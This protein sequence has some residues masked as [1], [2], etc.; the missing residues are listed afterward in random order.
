MK[1]TS[2]TETYKPIEA[3]AY[4]QKPKSSLFMLTNIENWAVAIGVFVID[5]YLL[6]TPPSYAALTGV[7][8][9]A[10]QRLIGCYLE[11][12]EA[13][14]RRNV[15]RVIRLQ[16]EH[17]AALKQKNIE[18]AKFN[19]KTGQ[20]D[21]LEELLKARRPLEVVEAELQHLAKQRKQLEADLELI[22][23]GCS[24]SYSLSTH[25]IVHIR[26]NI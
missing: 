6:K 15:T 22:K 8:I 18:D 25:S 19:N 13:K 17:I 9:L 12:Q 26:Q 11:S 3:D 2:T 5:A 4:N 7:L 23:S 1:V 24:P 10:E 14:D 20:I 16:D 21:V